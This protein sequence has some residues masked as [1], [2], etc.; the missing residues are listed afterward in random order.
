VKLQCALVGLSIGVV[1]IAACSSLN[2]APESSSRSRAAAAHASAF[3]GTWR[4]IAPQ[5]QLRLDGALSPPFTVAGKNAYEDHLAAA[6]KGNLEFDETTQLCSSPGLPRVML[7][8]GR[9]KIYVREDIVLMRFEW[10]NVFREINLGKKRQPLS[11]DSPITFNRSAE[12]LL[13]GTMMGKTE[14]QLIAESAGF[15]DK[16]LDNLLPSSDALKLTERWRRKGPEGLED[17]VTIDDPVNY[18]RP[19]STTLHFSRVAAEPFPE[20]VC[21]DRRHQGELTWPH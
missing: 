19:W 2:V 20:D 10:N 9:F 14:G 12:E 13:V 21:L 17:Q 3:D 18:A 4:L 8:P 16:L 6:A 11:A 15:S 7:A 1:L 5:T